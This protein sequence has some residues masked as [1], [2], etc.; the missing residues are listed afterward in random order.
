MHDSGAL[1]ERT[2]LAG[3]LSDT[4]AVVSR[5]MQEPL[6]PLEDLRGQLDRWADG[7]HATGWRSPTDAGSKADVALAMTLERAARALL[8]RVEGEA[9]ATRHLAQ[10]AIRYL[11]LDDDVEDDLGSIFGFDDDVDV[12]NAIA[13]RLG[14]DDL[15]IPAD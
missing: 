13:E 14:L 5:L 11:V 8:D 10:V 3:L 12:F 4:R 15:V 7:L 1:E 9:P 2:L 6:A